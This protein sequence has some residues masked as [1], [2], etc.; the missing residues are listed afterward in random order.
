MG[1]GNSRSQEHSSFHQSKFVRKKIGITGNIGSGKTTCCRLFELLGIPVYYAD[2]RGKQLM[3]ED[4]ILKHQIIN[5]LGP[6]AYA[7]DGSLA[8]AYIGGRV[9]EDKA[10]LAQL[11]ALVHPAVRRDSEQWHQEQQSPY[12]LHEAALIYE[13]GGEARLDAVI[14]VAAPEALRIQRVMERDGVSAEAVRAR[15]KHQMPQAEKEARADFILQNDGEQMLIPQVLQIHQKI[16][17][18][19]TTP[20]RKN[21]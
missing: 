1:V 13:T 14:V 20:P 3:V 9:F 18:W 21:N 6:D 19:E 7:E 11:N 5:L 12:T 4:D 15:I 8:R 16:L 2:Q 17:Q 10:L